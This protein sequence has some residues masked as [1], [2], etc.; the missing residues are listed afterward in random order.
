MVR[1]ARVVLVAALL[2]ICPAGA[3]AATFH[4]TKTADTNDG[5]CDA[6]CSLR[7]AIVAANANAGADDVT[8]PAGS[9][10]LSIAGTGEDAGATGDLDVTD[11]LNLSGAGAASTTI[12]GNGG[13]RVLDV[14]P[15]STGV[16]AMVADV[17]VTNGRA[18]AFGGGIRNAGTLLLTDSTISDNKA[19][20]TTPIINSIG[21][22]VATGAGGVTTISNCLVT[23][24]MATGDGDA[25]AAVGGGVGS[26][27]GETIVESST[28]IDNQ[29][30][31]SSP[32]A[33]GIGGGIGIVDGTLSVDSSTVS[34][35]GVVGFPAAG[36]GGI[37]VAC[38][39]FSPCGALSIS[40]ST[41]SD[42][43]AFAFSEVNGGGAFFSSGSFLLVNS[44]LTNNAAEMGPAPG[45]G[46]P[47]PGAN[48]G[49]LGTNGTIANATIESGTGTSGIHLQFATATLRNTI[50]ADSCSG[51]GITANARN[52][53]F[54]GNTCGF[55]GTDLIGLDPLLGALADNGGPTQTLKPAAGSAAIGNGD[56]ATPGSGGNACEAADQRGVARPV[57]SRCD[58][59]A[60]ESECGNG[61]L[62]AGEACDEGAASGSLTT[63]CSA[64]CLVRANNSA[65]DDG[66]VCTNLDKCQNGVCTSGSCRTG[67]C[68]YCGGT[69]SNAGGPCECTF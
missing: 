35:N 27:D 18:V 34:G 16:S 20:V 62:D 54:P 12:V 36:G 56:M 23:G 29:A 58:V 41:I 10:V 46:S 37:G 52:L 64:A 8:V 13:D 66:N 28:I 67:A 69:C 2:A 21:G 55:S 48:L 57:G 50:V 1:T 9:Y 15:L 22:G 11:D 39:V 45:V 47:A 49:I 43:D 61:N 44:T 31:A 7:E 14:D 63:C 5:A 24:N 53:E 19:E 26:F 4:V 33:P 59:G 40:G 30:F 25:G 32:N 38:E 17:R 6:D 51:T 60:Y 65:C 3:Q 68:T 42:N